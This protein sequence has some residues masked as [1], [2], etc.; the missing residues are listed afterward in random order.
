MHIRIHIY[1]YVYMYTYVYIC[2][3]TVDAAACRPAN[4]DLV[5]LENSSGV[6]CTVCDMTDMCHKLYT[7]MT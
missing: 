7:Y 1:K 6:T 4:S 5:P 2:F 3:V